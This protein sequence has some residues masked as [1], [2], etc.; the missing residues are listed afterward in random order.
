MSD[1]RKESCAY[2]GREIRGKVE[3][4]IHRDGLGE[5]PEVALCVKCGG[6][7]EPSCEEIW[8]A[9]ASQQAE[10]L[11]DYWKEK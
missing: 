5:G 4:R 1:E 10:K 3:F 7:S 6:D 8:R 2:C 11:K 9:L